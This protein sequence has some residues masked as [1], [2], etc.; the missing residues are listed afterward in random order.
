[1][2]KAACEVRCSTPRRPRRLLLQQHR[3]TARG[4]PGLQRESDLT[5]CLRPRGAK[6]ERGL[7]ALWSA[8]REDFSLDDMLKGRSLLLLETG[9]NLWLTPSSGPAS[10]SK[11]TFWL[12]TPYFHPRQCQATPPRQK[13]QS[14][15]R[16]GGLSQAE[17]ASGARAMPA[18][19]SDICHRRHRTRGCCQRGLCV[20]LFRPEL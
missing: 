20:G 2:S 19:V 12:I 18:R 11:C 17:G 14:L 7:T 15:C 1:M 3:G 6:G 8:A 4:N 13:T 5:Q 10:A 9:P 16:L